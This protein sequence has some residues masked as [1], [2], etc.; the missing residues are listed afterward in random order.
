MVFDAGRNIAL[1]TCSEISIGRKELLSHLRLAE[2]AIF[3]EGIGGRV[4]LAEEGDFLLAD[5]KTK[6]TVF[7]SREFL[8]IPSP[9]CEGEKKIGTLAHTLSTVAGGT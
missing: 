9:E 5:N 4:F 2:K 3:L 6:I 8:C 1:D 7:L